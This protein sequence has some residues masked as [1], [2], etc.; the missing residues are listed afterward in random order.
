[1]PL[2]IVVLTEIFMNKVNIM[3]IKFTRGFILGRNLGILLLSYPGRDQSV[4]AAKVNN[5]YQFITLLPALT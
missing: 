4:T 3:H 5:T 1:M 2:Y